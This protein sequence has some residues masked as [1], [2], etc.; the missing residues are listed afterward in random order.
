MII[1]VLRNYLLAMAIQHS[2]HLAIARSSVTKS[3]VKISGHKMYYVV[4]NNEH[5]YVYIHI[6]TD[7]Y[8]HTNQ[9][10][11]CYWVSTV[12]IAGSSPH[13]TNSKMKKKI[14]ISTY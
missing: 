12:Y 6:N 7:I 10:A 1:C 3:K 4:I 5:I 13:S 8:R 2:R 14:T 11:L 9:L